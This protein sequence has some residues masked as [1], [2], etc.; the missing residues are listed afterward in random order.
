MRR[1]LV[2]GALILTGCANT[3]G[4]LE[5]YRDRTRVDDPLLTIPE[6]QQR[7]RD[8][9]A[10]PEPSS[11]VAPRTYAEFPGPHGR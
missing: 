10:L 9:L 8:Q 6:Q 1:I 4:P 5:H 2:M 11:S 3:V 7:G